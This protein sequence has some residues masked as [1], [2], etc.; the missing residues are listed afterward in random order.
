MSQFTKA[1]ETLVIQSHF[2]NEDTMSKSV[3][4]K[5]N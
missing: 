4:A 2:K 1:Q 3:V 5:T